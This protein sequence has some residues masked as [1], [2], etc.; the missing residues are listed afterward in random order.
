MQAFEAVA[1][2]YGFHYD[3]VW[4]TWMN[5]C[6]RGDNLLWAR[7]SLLKRDWSWRKAKK[8][9]TKHF[10]TPAQTLALNAKLHTMT[11]N[12]GEKIQE[13]GDRF[14]NLVNELQMTD[15]RELVNIFKYK[16]PEKYRHFIFGHRAADPRRLQTVS[17]VIDFAQGF[18]QYN[19]SEYLSSRKS[20]SSHKEKDKS[21]HD[22]PK[23]LY[24]DLHGKGSLSGTH[25]INT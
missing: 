16:L 20:G 3:D 18:E 7:R 15:G 1:D 19:D 14:M 17:E 5:A 13:F 21:R 4:D 12:P 6:L 25:S 2:T 9:L 10:D 24:C 22:H 11:P 23:K 8:V